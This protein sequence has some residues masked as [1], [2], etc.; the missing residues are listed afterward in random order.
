M[1]NTPL[2][3]FCTGLAAT[4]ILTGNPL[5]GLVSAALSPLA[6]VIHT[7]AT[8]VLKKQSFFPPDSKRFIATVIA[9][10]TIGLTAALFKQPISLINSVAM[11]LLFDGIDLFAYEHTHCKSR[12][13]WIINF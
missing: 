1:D 12:P 5:L 9:V 7:L 13:F 8:E 6:T 2:V 10:G 11:N 3:S 4:T